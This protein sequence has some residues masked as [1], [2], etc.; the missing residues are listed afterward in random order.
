MLNNYLNRPRRK[1]WIGAA[2]GAA[3]GI[4]STLFGAS[5]Q[6]KAQEEQY[7]L[8]QAMEARNTGLTSAANMTQAYANYV[9]AL[10]TVCAFVE[11]DKIFFTLT[12]YIPVT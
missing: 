8:Q 10:C 2:I 4:G 7:R 5:Q 1:A 6:K 3:V 9:C 12:H 11:G